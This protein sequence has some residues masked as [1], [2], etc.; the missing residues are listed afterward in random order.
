M[1]ASF[2]QKAIGKSG[3]GTLLLQRDE[4]IPLPSFH[5]SIEGMMDDLL[6]KN[7]EHSRKNSRSTLFSK[8]R[9]TSKKSIQPTIP[10]HRKKGPQFQPTMN[11]I[12]NERTRDVPRMVERKVGDYLKED[13]GNQRALV[14]RVVD[15]MPWRW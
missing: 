8:F 6:T 7:E 11:A 9:A 2:F 13:D 10:I 12:K 4:L 1:T 14:T 15:F 3:E 5:S